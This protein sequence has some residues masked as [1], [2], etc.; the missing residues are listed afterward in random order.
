MDRRKSEK[1]KKRK[2]QNTLPK[3]DDSIILR[4]TRGLAI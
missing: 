1:C 2:L 4:V 3:H